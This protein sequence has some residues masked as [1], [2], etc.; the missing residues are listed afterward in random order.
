MVGS[1]IHIINFVKY[2]VNQGELEV[3]TE[4]KS[5]FGSVTIT[6]FQIFE[7]NKHLKD[8]CDKVDK[9]VINFQRQGSGWI[10]SGNE[11]WQQLLFYKYVPLIYH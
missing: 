2:T 4:T 9:S 11:S 5:C 8:A 1:L 10:Y 7:I 3:D 6:I